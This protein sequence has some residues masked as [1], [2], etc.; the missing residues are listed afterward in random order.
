MQPV[1]DGVSSVDASFL[2]A[3]ETAVSIVH[4]A[5]PRVSEVVAVHGAGVIGLLVVATLRACGVAVLAVE[6]DATRRALAAQ[7]AATDDNAPVTRAEYERLEKMM[8]AVACGVTPPGNPGNQRGDS[9]STLSPC[10]DCG[11]RRPGSCC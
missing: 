3:A 11:G 1:P 4:D 7:R 6:P 10:D 5:H 2:P 8:V 9:W